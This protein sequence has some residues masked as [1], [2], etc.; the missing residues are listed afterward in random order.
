MAPERMS[1]S[2]RRW[3]A[4]TDSVI[5]SAM[6]TYSTMPDG[7]AMAPLTRSAATASQNMLRIVI[8]SR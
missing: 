7:G 4:G 6:P 8:T 1:S 2:R 5:H 3:I